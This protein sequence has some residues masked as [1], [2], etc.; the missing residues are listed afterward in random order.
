MLHVLCDS[1][2]SFALHDYSADFDQCYLRSGTTEHLCN[3]TNNRFY[4]KLHEYDIFS[5]ETG[6]SS[7]SIPIKDMRFKLST[8]DERRLSVWS[9]TNGR[10][11]S[12]LIFHDSAGRDA[13]AEK[14]EFLN[15]SYDS[16]LRKVVMDTIQ[17]FMR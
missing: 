4:L 7:T 16:H 5:N 2:L 9:A 3:V 12:K 17:S 11:K 6:R 10:Q 14:L 13:F 1:L 8:S 15:S